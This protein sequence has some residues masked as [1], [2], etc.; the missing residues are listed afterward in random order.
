MFS[1]A[2]NPN[3]ENSRQSGYYYEFNCPESSLL[4]IPGPLNFYNTDLK[5][6]EN[7]LNQYFSTD[8]QLMKCKI[9]P[10]TILVEWPPLSSPILKILSAV[11]KEDESAKNVVI[12]TGTKKEVE[13]CVK[14]AS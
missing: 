11:E 8:T 5:G 12:Y 4:P 7:Q 10:Q 14:Y 2:N 6:W 9:S 3:P 1:P 13:E